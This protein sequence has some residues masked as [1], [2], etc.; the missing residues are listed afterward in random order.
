MLR[1][2]LV[3]VRAALAASPFS[4]EILVIDNASS[5]GSAEQVATEFPEARL[6]AN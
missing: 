2:C 4:A 6:F 1:A 5:D 3:S